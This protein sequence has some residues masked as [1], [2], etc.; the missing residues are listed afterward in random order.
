MNGPQHNPSANGIGNGAPMPR[1]QMGVPAPAGPSISM[2]DVVAGLRQWWRWCVL[3][4]VLL[5]A[6]SGGAI[7]ATFKPTYVATAILTIE[8]RAPFIVFDQKAQ[9]RTFSQTQLELIR[10]SVV[11]R[12]V[13]SE[14]K[15]AALPESQQSEDPLVWLSTGL[16]AAFRGQSELCEISFS[17]HDPKTAATVANAI[18]DEY[19]AYQTEKRERDNGILKAEL[20]EKIKAQKDGVEVLKASVLRLAKDATGQETVIV[21]NGADLTVMTNSLSALAT[22][23][24]DAEAERTFL[25]LQVRSLE[26]KV[27][28][29]RVE[30]SE[31]EIRRRIEVNSDVVRRK[32]ELQALEAEL[33]KAKELAGD[34][35]DSIYGGRMKRLE[36]EIPRKR[37]D[38][39]D[40]Q[41]ELRQELETQLKEEA[42]TEAKDNIEQK[43][44]QLNDAIDKASYFADAVR[45][46]RDKV[47][48]QGDART[49]LDFERDELALRSGVLDRLQTRLTEM[50]TEKSAPAQAY[51]EADAIVP[52]KPLVA[53]PYR[54]LTIALVLSFGL[55][56]GLAV[57]WERRTRRIS[58]ADHF[59]PGMNLNMLGE[60]SR[61]PARVV[62]HRVGIGVDD[63]YS[64]DRLLYEE[65]V[66]ALRVSLT[67]SPEFGDVQTIVVTSAVSGEG[68][69]SL[70]AALAV[71]I[72][73]GTSEPTLLIDA[74][75][76]APDL[77]LLL[78]LDQ[79]PGLSDVLAGKSTLEE[80][81]VA[82]PRL[83]LTVL[84]QGESTHH[85]HALLRDGAF[86]A[87]LAQAK[88]RFRHIVVDTPPV[89]AVSEAVI[90][91]SAGD[92]VV[93]CTMRDVSRAPQL[94]R[95]HERLTRAGVRVLGA[96]VNGVPS[97]T[98]AYQY[99]AYGYGSAR[100]R[101]A[102]SAASPDPVSENG[103]NP[104]TDAD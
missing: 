101:Y 48:K 52:T 93:L 42:I 68:K 14:A 47:G 39:E 99:G 27:Q 8:D 46:E 57:L 86:P 61:M 21:G 97:R 4:G 37:Q 79:S 22:K 18:M 80:A 70:A 73:R 64:R 63:A 10:S 15:I 102:R 51:K 87:L 58:T 69:S 104:A 28:E 49:E 30:I 44:R 6:A 26:K 62:S 25:E 2:Q 91:A 38:L 90:L 59:A 36:S 71:S 103:D 98:W 9:S 100:G 12:R 94:G 96:V 72:A 75:M 76:R 32:L 50:E 23:H 88:K 81:C 53:W 29:T 3:G 56:F 77:H 41:A 67:H 74:D 13:A 83:G 84:P 66:D 17:A 85:P 5:A 40:R 16:K 1:P 20:V 55:P 54:P 95:A 33:Q 11:L 92:G 7:F 89:L 35:P 31:L 24:I 65:S 34:L 82:V 60:V 78:K 45:A 43:K 19:L